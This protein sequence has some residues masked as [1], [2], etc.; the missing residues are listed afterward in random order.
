MTMKTVGKHRL[1]AAATTPSATAADLTDEEAATI[2]D[3]DWIE[4]GYI[5][6]PH[7]V[8][9]E[10]KVQPLT[11][12]PEER[13][14]MPGPRWLAPPPLRLRRLGGSRREPPRRVELEG[15]RTMISKGQEVWLVKLEGVD[16]PEDAA[17]LR[18]HRLLIPPSARPPL[19]DEDEFYVQVWTGQCDP[20]SLGTA[21]AAAK[22]TRAERWRL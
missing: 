6:Q 16:S 17:L 8:Y 21:A 19:E 7:G 20:G 9:G 22:R 12:E 18:G 14:G 11:D 15:G 4:V 3:D 5:T 1:P 10:M 2:S 13:L